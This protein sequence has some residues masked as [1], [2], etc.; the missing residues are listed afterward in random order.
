VLHIWQLF[1]RGKAECGMLVQCL[2]PAVVW[3]LQAGL[4]GVQS[5]L[6]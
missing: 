3:S 2:S 1:K 4:H 6:P 5:L